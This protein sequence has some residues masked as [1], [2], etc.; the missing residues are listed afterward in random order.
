MNILQNMVFC[1]E[2]LK[3]DLAT[4]ERPDRKL[5]RYDEICHELKTLKS[6]GVTH[7]ME[8]SNLGMGRDISFIERLEKEL[9]NQ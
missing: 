6:L 4:K 9:K 1:H 7:I 3:L 2:H 5:D 8:V